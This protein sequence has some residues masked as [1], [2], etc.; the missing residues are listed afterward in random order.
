MNE[1]V[2][3]IAQLPEQMPQ[4]VRFLEQAVGKPDIAVEVLDRLVTLQIK[5][6]EHQAK[7]DYAVAMNQFQSKKE[8][9]AH[10]RTGITAGHAKFS[11]SDFPKMVKEITPWLETCG[12]SFAHRQDP[13]FMN[14]KGEI[15]GIVVWCTIRHISG[16]QQEYSF[17]AM[18]DE[19]LKGK[20]SP[21]QLIQ[22]AINYAKRQTLAMGLGLATS[23]D[24]TDD[25]AS[26]TEAITDEQAADL[27]SLIDEVKADKAKFIKFMKVE[28]IEDITTKDYRRAIAALEKKR[29][30]G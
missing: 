27:L 10:N 18:P 26:K 8:I 25:D 29:K 6:M 14:E 16:H 9:I 1:Q 21:S 22:M 28:R 15:T 12:L 2:K 3:S 11:Y 24:I 4:L 13:P 5:V 30:A 17:P 20:V 19:R 23:E 7:M